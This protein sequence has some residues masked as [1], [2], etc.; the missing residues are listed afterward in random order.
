MR[1]ILSEI[2]NNFIINL[3]DFGSKKYLIPKEELVLANILKDLG[4][5]RMGYIN[6]NSGFNY[7]ASI[8]SAG[9]ELYRRLSSS[10]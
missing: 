3:V 1:E 9:M 7:T 2:E 10:P 4:F 5:V 8:T 6:D